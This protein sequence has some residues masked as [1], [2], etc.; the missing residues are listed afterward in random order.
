MTPKRLVFSLL[1]VALAFA[2]YSAY[3]SKQQGHAATSTVKRDTVV[4]AVYATGTVEPVYWAKLASYRTSRLMEI[5]H[6]EGDAIKTGDVIARMENRAETERLEEARARLDFAKKELARNQL[7]IR[8]SAIS[9]KQLEDSQREAREMQAQVQAA[10][11]AVDDLTLIA[12]VDGIVLRRDIELGEIAEAGQVLFWV[13]KPQP[14]RIT[15]D[16]DEEDIAQVKLGQKA[17]IK[18]DAFP[19]QVFEGSINEITPKGDPVNKV[20]RIRV[21]LPDN[22]PLLTGMTTEVNIIVETI[23]NALVVPS[24]SETGGMV[25]KM[26]GG[27]T[28]AVAVKTGIRNESLVQVTEGLSEGDSIL[29]HAPM[30][31]KH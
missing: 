13:G 26:D 22:A 4:H 30:E 18:A 2:G 9:R 31:T 1:I 29:T 19:G 5:V 3:S 23:P 25:W 27:S 17:L 28:K 11:R 15:A 10:Q 7:L 8:Q 21:S 12:P 6:H 20:F 14:L 16:V 24:S